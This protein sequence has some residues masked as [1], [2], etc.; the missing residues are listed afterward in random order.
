ML[1]K[2]INCIIPGLYGQTEGK[3]VKTKDILAKMSID[4]ALDS[5]FIAEALGIESVAVFNCT[6][7]AMHSPNPQ[8]R[9]DSLYATL[10]KA[11]GYCLAQL[12]EKECGEPKIDFHIHIVSVS[13]PTIEQRLRAIRI[14]HKLNETITSLIL[15]QGCS[16]I[17]DALGVAKQLLAASPHANILITS[18]NNMLTHVHNRLRQYAHRGNL[19]NW[20]W[21]VIFGEGVGAMIVGGADSIRENALCWSVDYIDK[22][23]VANDWRVAEVISDD[24]F[25]EIYIKA[26]EVR[27]TYLSAIPQQ[28]QKHRKITDNF[29]SFA[30]V[31]LHESNP[32][33]I[34]RVAEEFAIPAEKLVSIS[35]SVGTLACVSSFSLLDAAWRSLYTDSSVEEKHGKILLA[36]I[37]ESGG[38][39][40]AGSVVLS[41]YQR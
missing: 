11:V 16:G 10:E 31:L 22:E 2:A 14:T 29:D 1:L 40:T 6:L 26:K 32:K 23:V 24:G 30:K 27:S 15:Q 5:G 9:N 37:G 39:I 21:P 33:M 20:L 25:A 18:E 13:E 12:V 19:D 4:K 35:A 41:H 28:L 3:L 36:A 17:I 7:E 38:A 8:A 34:K